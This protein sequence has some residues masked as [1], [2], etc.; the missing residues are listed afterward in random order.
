MF[1]IIEAWLKTPCLDMPPIL[2]YSQWGKEDSTRKSG[3]RNGCG[4]HWELSFTEIIPTGFKYLLVFVDTFSGWLKTYPT[5][6]DTA[7]IVTKKIF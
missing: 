4:E 2:T 7:P 5:W 1:Q 3:S 6:K